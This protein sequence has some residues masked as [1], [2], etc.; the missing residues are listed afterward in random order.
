MTFPNGS[1]LFNLEL[2]FTKSN[3][4]LSWKSFP[5]I[6]ALDIIVLQEFFLIDI[7]NSDTGALGA[8]IVRVED[9]MSFCSER[10][11]ENYNTI[12]KLYQAL[13]KLIKTECEAN[14]SNF[15]G[16]ACVVRNLI[17]KANNPEASI[18]KHGYCV[19][20]THHQEM[21]SQG[22]SSKKKKV[23]GESSKQPQND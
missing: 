22:K 14:S 12:P 20:E 11:M 13:L 4:V 23:Q 5:S 2:G 7:A 18:L 9:N 15:R 6:V 19:E 10:M 3:K 8:V 16:T 21:E 1:P 17:S